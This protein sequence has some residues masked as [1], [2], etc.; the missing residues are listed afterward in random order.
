MER[1]VSKSRNDG[2]KSRKLKKMYDTEDIHE[3]VDLSSSIEIEEKNKTD[4]GNIKKTKSVKLGRSSED[5]TH[6]KS[7]KRVRFSGQVQIFPSLNHT[8]DEKHEIEEE[9]LLQGKRFSKLEDEIVKEA[10]HKYIE[11]HNLGEQGLKKVL[12]ARSYPEIK[13]CW[14]E[15]GRSIPYRPT[16]AVYSRAQI[17]FRR[18][19]SR[20]WTEEECEIL[21]KLQKEHGNNWKR[22]ADELGKHRRHVKDTWRRLKQSNQNKGSWTQEEYQNLFD[23]VNTDLRLKLSEE[24]KS[25]HGMLRDNIAWNAISEN[26]STRNPTN[27]CLKWYNQLTSSMVDK[28]EWADVDDYRLIDALFELDASCIEDVDWDNLLDHRHGEICRKRWNQMILHIGQLGN[29]SFVDQVEVLAKRYRP[30]LVEVREAWDN[31]PIV[32]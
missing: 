4:K 16:I 18:S 11:L 27:C 13:G 5:P 31:K 12:N 19:E 10:V 21:L 30:D 14:K 3:D 7:G 32:P 22:I 6:E 8:S 29:K 15:I 25:K 17:L 2:N 28:G 23:L 20:K 24:K 26:L 9:N 1:Y